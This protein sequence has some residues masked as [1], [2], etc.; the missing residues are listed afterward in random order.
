MAQNSDNDLHTIRKNFH[1]LA[2][3]NGGVIPHNIEELA[4]LMKRPEGSLNVIKPGSELLDGN[5]GDL[6]LIRLVT[7]SHIHL[8][9]RD[10]NLNLHFTHA[11]PGTGTRIAILDL[12]P[13]LRSKI[14]G[15]DLTWSPEKIC[16]YAT[17]VN[18]P[19]KFLMAE[20]TQAPYQLQVCPDGSILQSGDEGCQVMG[21]RVIVDGKPLDIS[22]AINTWKDTVTAIEILLKGSSPDGF[23]FEVIC[24]NLSIVML[25]TGFEA[26]CKRR[27]LEL[28]EE[29]I[30]A[31]FEEL[32]KKFISKRD[33]DSGLLERIIQESET[34]GISPLK[35]LIEDKKINF[36]NHEKCKD[37]F[38]KGYG[39]RFYESIGI[40][41]KCLKKFLAS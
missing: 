8:L 24:C 3:Q 9:K 7:G 41:T 14:I 34:L 18:D 2:E 26:Y 20:G 10:S 13:L 19:N 5:L 30:K 35:I 40:L 21:T 15:I 12:K 33:R 38:N 39:I 16:L 27:F 36:Q 23:I 37:A 1:N 32:A 17:D 22:S 11:S 29:G 4:E 31:N 25:V 6:Q 28:D